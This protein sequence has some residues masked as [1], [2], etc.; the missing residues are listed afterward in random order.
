M[1]VQGSG[2]FQRALLLVFDVVQIARPPRIRRYRL[3]FFKHQPPEL[4]DTEFRD[5][6][7]DA[8][9]RAVFLLSEPGENPGNS[10]CDGQQFLFRKERV[11]Q[12]RLVENGAQS[13][14]DVKLE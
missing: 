14:A 2:S 5:E 7:L 12:F 10:L 6:E 4:F 9:S 3:P 1:A 11:K 8:R 13:T